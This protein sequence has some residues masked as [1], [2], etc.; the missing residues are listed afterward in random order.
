M[1]QPRPTHATAHA[2]SPPQ[3]DLPR[4]GNLPFRVQITLWALRA[5]VALHLGK[6]PDNSMIAT[7]YAR[8]GWAD[9]AQAIDRLTRIAMGYWPEPLI[10][11][12]IPCGCLTQDEAT[13]GLALGYL[14]QNAPELAQHSLEQ[15]LPTEAADAV[16]TSLA[17]YAIG[18]REA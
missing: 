16:L 18:L 14:L 12:P 1:H 9:G 17:A 4:L 10:V 8:M 7:A 2:P 6:L 15:R 5:Q 11:K 13:L 3:T